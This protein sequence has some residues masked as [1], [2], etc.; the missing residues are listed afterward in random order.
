MSYCKPESVIFTISPERESLFRCLNPRCRNLYHFP[1]EINIDIVSETAFWMCGSCGYFY[2]YTRMGPY[3]TKY[4]IVRQK[5]Y[6]SQILGKNLIKK[7]LDSYW[8][9]TKL[10][11]SDYK[12]DTTEIKFTQE[13]LEITVTQGLGVSSEVKEN[14]ENL[15]AKAPEAERVGEKEP[16]IRPPEKNKVIIIVHNDN[17]YSIQ[18]HNQVGREPEYK[19]SMNQTNP[20]NT[21]QKKY[22][23][24]FLR[25]E[26]I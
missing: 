2:D 5:G 6:L 13:S 22:V 17:G 21:P 19:S 10:V 1:L 20:E 15:I 3:P 8:R 24:Y 14:S 25:T 18:S 16:E 9:G 4:K 12:E 7:I 23:I 11:I 26:S